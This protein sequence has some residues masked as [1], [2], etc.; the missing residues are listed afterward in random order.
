MSCIYLINGEA[1]L[2]I[3][4][5]LKCAIKIAWIIAPNTLALLCTICLLS[6]QSSYL[7][8]DR[9]RSP[10]YRSYLSLFLEEEVVFFISLLSQF[11]LQEKKQKVRVKQPH[12]SV[13]LMWHLEFKEIQNLKNTIFYQKKI[14]ISAC[15]HSID[16]EVKAIFFASIFQKCLHQYLSTFSLSCTDR[17]LKSLLTFVC[18]F[19]VLYKGNQ[20]PWSAQHC[21]VSSLYQF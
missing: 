10:L 21:A 3:E 16:D 19:T 14:H 13:K 15:T 8:T 1:F 17:R 11:F 9:R 20:L 4:N 6:H 2:L 7:G 5:P 12:R 18:K